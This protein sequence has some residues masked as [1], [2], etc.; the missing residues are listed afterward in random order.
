MDSGIGF[1]FY[2]TEEELVNHYLRLKMLGYDDQVQEIP[3][4]NVLD[5]EPWDLPRIQHPQAVI[6]NNSN[7]QVWYFFCPRNYKYSNSNRAKRTTNG[8]YWKVTSKDRRINKNGIKKT[9]V[10]YQ[11]RSK[12]V[13]T[14]WVMHEYNPTFGFRTQR[15]FV[16]CK[17]KRRPDD[18]D[19]VPTQ[20]A[21][22]SSTVVASASGNNATDEDSQLQAYVDSFGGINERDYNLNSAMQWPTY[23][24]N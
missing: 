10:F 18:A 21:G 9:L 22:G 19:D 6:A 13:K 2:P 4:V 20:E 17:L 7:D 11:G 15:D 3:E 5:F 12:G 16:L 1:R 23:Y 24:Y 14:N 8:G